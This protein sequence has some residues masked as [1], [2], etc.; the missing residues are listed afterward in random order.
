MDGAMSFHYDKYI[1]DGLVSSK[2]VALPDIQLSL[3]THRCSRGIPTHN[4]LIVLRACVVIHLYYLFDL[5]H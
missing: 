4:W 2:L 1:I 5:A 3:I